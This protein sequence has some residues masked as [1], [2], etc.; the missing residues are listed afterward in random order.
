MKYQKLGSEIG[1]LVDEK[2]IAYGDSFNKSKNV[3]VQLYPDGVKVEQ[4]TDMLCLVRII[5]KLFRIANKKGAFGESPYQDLAGYSLLGIGKDREK[6][7][8]L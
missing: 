2:Q 1:K 8:E 6:E 5:D 3:L 4:Y 7:D